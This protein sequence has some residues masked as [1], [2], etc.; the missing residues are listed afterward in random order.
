VS[1]SRERIVAAYFDACLAELRAPKAGNVHDFS[2]WHGMTVVDFELSAAVT[3][4]WIARPGAAVGARILGATRATR[5]AVSCNTNLGIVLMCAPLAAAAERAEPGNPDSLAPCV[6]AVLKSLDVRDAADAFRAIA[7]AAPAG[8]GEA[9][10]HDVREAPTVT[11]GEAMASAAH[12][13]RIAFNYSNDFVDVFGVGIPRYLDALARWQEPLWAA[14]A[15][16]FAMMSAFPDTHIAR[17]H[18]V[19]AAEAARLAAVRIDRALTQ[20]D[21]PAALLPEI[22]VLDRELKAQGRNPGTSADLTVATI[23]AVSLQR[24]LQ[25]ER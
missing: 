16:H 6:S 15:V 3:R 2:D 4:D 21:D 19:A 10:E 1:L 18:G 20:A 23:F 14:A 5:A 22:F 25:A 8:L 7:L 24:L 13:D 9:P 17:E 11:L 12:R